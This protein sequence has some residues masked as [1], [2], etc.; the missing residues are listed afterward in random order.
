MIMPYSQTHTHTQVHTHTHT[1]TPGIVKPQ[2]FVELYMSNGSSVRIGQF[3][4][5][6][7]MIILTEQNTHNVDPRISSKHAMYSFYK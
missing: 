4:G 7:L 1:Y 6:Y 5:L 2:F 3:L